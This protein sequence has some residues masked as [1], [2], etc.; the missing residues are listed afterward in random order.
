MTDEGEK[1][2]EQLAR[3]LE[4]RLREKNHTRPSERHLHVPQVGSGGIYYL[5]SRLVLTKAWEAALEYEPK[6]KVARLLCGNPRSLI[7]KVLRETGLNF[8]QCVN[9]TNHLTRGTADKIT[10]VTGYRHR[11]NTLSQLEGA[12]YAHVTDCMMTPFVVARQAEPRS[13]R[14]TK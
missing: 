9:L 10:V 6:E 1:D 7:L 11:P 5:R 4:L 13:D 2:V 12:Q 14:K 8:P 3:Q